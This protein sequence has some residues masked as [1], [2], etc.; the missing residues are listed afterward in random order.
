MYLNFIF[1]SE[2]KVFPIQISI[3]NNLFN[4]LTSSGSKRSYIGYL[5]LPALGPLPPPWSQICIYR[6]WPPMCVNRPWA[7]IIYLPAL[8]HKVYLPSQAPSVTPG[9]Y[10]PV[11]VKILLLPQLLV[12]LIS[13]SVAPPLPLLLLLILLLLLLLMIILTTKN[14][15]AAAKSALNGP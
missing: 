11:Q 12:L 7:K 4:L 10:L 3:E 1:T 5:Y 2:L 13:L 8:V 14:A 6:P 9:L 15:F